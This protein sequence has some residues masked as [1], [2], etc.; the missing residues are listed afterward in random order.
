M[1][2]P[3]SL[4]FAWFEQYT[5]PL[6]LSLPFLEAFQLTANLLISSFVQKYNVSPSHPQIENG[7]GSTEKVIGLIRNAS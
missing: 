1:T 6:A 5:C 2:L 7:M 4:F 3:K